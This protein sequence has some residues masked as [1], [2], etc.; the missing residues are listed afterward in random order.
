MP[1]APREG[2]VLDNPSLIQPLTPTAPLISSTRRTRA[3]LFPE[4]DL[5]AN[6]LR[7]LGRRRQV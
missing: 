3:D 7:S 5:A 4:Q 6:S 2:Q 1:P